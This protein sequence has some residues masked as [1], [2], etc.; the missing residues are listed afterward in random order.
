MAA[1]SAASIPPCSLPCSGGRFDG[2]KGYCTP[3]GRSGCSGHARM[4]IIIPCRKSH[5]SAQRRRERR[6][7]TQTRQ[8]RSSAA[9]RRWA[10]RQKEFVSWEGKRD[11]TFHYST[12]R[13]Q[14]RRTKEMRRVNRISDF[15]CKLHENMRRGQAMRLSGEMCK[16]RPRPQ[17]E[18]GRGYC[19]KTDR[20]AEM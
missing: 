11:S 8:R 14:R 3:V 7:T 18:G 12:F 2:R 16:T 20:K 5:N 4:R 9:C 15:F 13:T 19:S 6:E 17:K 10:G 1:L